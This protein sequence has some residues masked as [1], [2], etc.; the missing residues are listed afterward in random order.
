LE[1]GRLRCGIPRARVR[2]CMGAG[3]RA[4]AE[5]AG[6]SERGMV[7]PGGAPVGAAAGAPSGGRAG[8]SPLRG[9]PR[10]LRPGIAVR[11]ARPAGDAAGTLDARAVVARAVPAGRD[12]CATG[13][14]EGAGG[15][16]GAARRRPRR[17]FRE[18]VHGAA[19][20]VRVT[21]D[22]ILRPGVATSTNALRS[23]EPMGLR[24]PVTTP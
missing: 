23:M 12:R 19:G 9:R 8:G 5:R 10:P 2:P 1:R 6:R 17:P 13:S 15:A 24:P 22:Y 7:G 21:F 20:D 16:R 4:D 18:T 3:A 14:G 11:V